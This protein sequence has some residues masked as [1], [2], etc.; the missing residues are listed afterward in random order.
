MTGLT[1]RPVTRK[2]WRTYVNSFRW[3]MYMAMDCNMNNGSALMAHR[4][5]L[6]ALD[7]NPRMKRSK[8]AKKYIEETADIDFMF[9]AVG[10]METVIENTL[11]R[12]LGSRGLK[13]WSKD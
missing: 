12:G 5:L 4:A 6:K 13:Y 9:A 8:F 2:E 10:N 3:D 1:E 11:A 7:K